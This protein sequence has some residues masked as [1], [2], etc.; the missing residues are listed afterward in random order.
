MKFVI[1]IRIVVSGIP[2]TDKSRQHFV[3]R[4]PLHSAF[5]Q[6]VCL[7]Q[8]W[9]SNFSWTT[10][11]GLSRVSALIRYVRIPHC[12]FVCV[13]DEFIEVHARELVSTALVIA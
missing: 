3:S 10:E 4:C 1:S 8:I 12:F 11:Y 13:H 6:F 7:G 9:D 2:T 5:V